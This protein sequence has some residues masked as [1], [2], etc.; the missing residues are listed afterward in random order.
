MKKLS[1][2]DFYE[3]YFDKRPVFLDESAGIYEA[4]GS[5][6]VTMSMKMQMVGRFA[7][8]RIQRGV[9]FGSQLGDTSTLGGVLLFD[10]KNELR[11]VYAEDGGAPYDIA[12]IQAA[13]D[14]IRRG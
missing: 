5:K 9:K 11:Y 10:H 1:V 6:K 7:K 2:I 13:L 3:N 12:L 14:E 4:L 8:A